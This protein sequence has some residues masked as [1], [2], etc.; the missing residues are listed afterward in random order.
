MPD[1]AQSD[2]RRP[3]PRRTVTSSQSPSQM[4]SEDDQ[5][6]IVPPPIDTTL[7]SFQFPSLSTASKELVQPS[8]GTSSFDSRDYQFVFRSKPITNSCA[9]EPY[10]VLLLVASAQGYH[11]SKIKNA[12]YMEDPRLSDC[13][14]AQCKTVS[15]A[16]RKSKQ[17]TPDLIYCSSMY[18][19]LS[20]MQL[21]CPEW[22]D[23]VETM[24]LDELRPQTGELASSKRS[25]AVSLSADF[26][27]VSFDNIGHNTDPLWNDI[28]PESEEAVTERIHEFVS[29]Y[30]IPN[31][32]L[33]RTEYGTARPDRLGNVGWNNGKN[34]AN[35]T[36]SN[37]IGFRSR[38]PTP[39]HS[40]HSGSS[41]H[42]HPFAK[43]V[44]VVSHRSILTHLLGT[45]VD[46]VSPAL[47]KRWKHGDIRKVFVYTKQ[48][49]GMAPIPH[50]QNRMTL[51]H[52]LMTSR[53]VRSLQRV[54]SV[55]H[56]RPTERRSKTPN[57]PKTNYQRHLPFGRPSTSIPSTSSGDILM[58]ST[59]KFESHRFTL[60]SMSAAF[61]SQHSGHQSHHHEEYM[62]VLA[63]KQTQSEKPRS[64]TSRKI[65][66][67]NGGNAIRKARSVASVPVIKRKE[68]V[69]PKQH[70]I[71]RIVV[72]PPV[73]PQA[74]M[75]AT[76]R[77]KRRSNKVSHY[78]A[79]GKE[80]VQ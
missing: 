61:V 24:A 55:H 23:D 67:E 78:Q 26:R 44:V 64:R 73:S 14:V 36:P 68:N 19:A 10:K 66:C 41:D 34:K 7:G 30:L 8:R 12:E 69:K 72:T 17:Q 58:T 63:M 39:T 1:E 20:T 29:K 59:D 79:R 65:R 33:I 75:Q 11:H 5:K 52:K 47:C 13:G 57:A 21:V 80:L 22:Y 48:Q 77:R 15:T 37:T 74:V 35:H 46:D 70:S 62:P 54:Q 28:A 16:L 76:S 9:F 71:P 56:Q 18:R 6:I 60:T 4:N 2:Y 42:R 27:K 43:R 3:E 32:E 49:L 50:I 38:S 51:R 31:E 45:V 25:D 53:S 40:A